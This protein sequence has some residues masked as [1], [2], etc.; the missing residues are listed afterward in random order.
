MDA[1]FIALLQDEFCHQIIKDVNEIVAQAIS[2]TQ[3]MVSLKAP[4]DNLEL[5]RKRSLQPQTAAD[6]ADYSIEMFDI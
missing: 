3:G 1:H 4:I 6:V 5:E 2:V